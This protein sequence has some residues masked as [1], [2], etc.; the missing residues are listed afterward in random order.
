[1]SMQR[2][3]RLDERPPKIRENRCSF[4]LH[5]SEHPE[6]EVPVRWLLEQAM[7][8]DEVGGRR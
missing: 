1:M 3:K 6:G 2:N 4:Q 8:Y 5:G 7:K